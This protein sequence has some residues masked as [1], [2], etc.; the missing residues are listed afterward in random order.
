MDQM[1]EQFSMII[2]RH[3]DCIHNCDRPRMA[4]QPL[5]KGGTVI[6]VIEDVEFP[7]NRCDEHMSGEFRQFLLGCGCPPAIVAQAGY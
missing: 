7:V 5:V 6:K 3:H 4:P 1:E 2:Q